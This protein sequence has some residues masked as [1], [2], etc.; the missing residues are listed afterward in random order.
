MTTATAPLRAIS[1]YVRTRQH[2]RNLLTVYETYAAFTMIAKSE[3]LLNLQ[4]ADTVDGIAGAVAIG[5]QP[6]PMGRLY[7]FLRGA[8]T[9][10]FPAGPRV[11]D[12]A[13]RSILGRA[14]II[15]G[16]ACLAIA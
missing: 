6:S 1:G 3:Y 2:R 16:I 7:M 14:N 5:P 12:R 13:A 9:K 15:F 10:I 4:L 8:L 11:M